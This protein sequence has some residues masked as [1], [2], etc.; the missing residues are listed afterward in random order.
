MYDSIRRVLS[1]PRAELWVL[2]VATLLVAP[3]ISAG[4]AADDFIHE[5]ALLG[6]GNPLAGFRRAPLDLFWFA[7]PEFNPRLLDEGVVPWWIDPSVRFAFFRPLA[8]ATHWLDHLLVPGNAVVMHLHTVL[9]HVAGLV[10]VRSLFR[11]ILGPGWVATLALCLYALDDARGAP[12]AWVANRNELIALALSVWAITWHHQGR[13]GDRLRARLAPAVLGVAML[14]SEGAIAVTAY[15]FAYTLFLDEGTRRERLW[16]LA[17]YALVVVA[18]AALYRGLGYGVSRSGLYFDPLR[19]PVAFA[20]VFPERFTMLWLAQLGGPW[21]EGWNAYPVMFPGLEYVVVVLAGVIIA[22]TFA[23]FLPLLRADKLARFWLTGAVVGTLPACGGFPGDRLLPW[24]GIGAMGLTAQFFA[25]VVES[26]P[27]PGFRGAAAR[28]GAFAIIVAH[29]GLGPLL[30]PLRAAG[31]AQVRGA[32]DRADRTIPSDR[33]VEQR[34]VIYVNPAADPFASYI[35]VTRAALGIPRPRSQRWLATGT[36]PVHVTR[37]DERTLRVRPE[38]GFL[39]MPSERMLR[40]TASHPF[41]VGE[42]IALDELQVTIS[43]VTSDGRPAEALERFARPLED[44]AY[45]WLSWQGDGYGPFT[46]PAIGQE[47]TAPAADLVTVA[48]GQD[49]WITRALGRTRR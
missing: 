5:L 34:L 20:R 1:R 17:P 24:V 23:L 10:A 26:R 36:T 19:D 6:S 37:V 9:W 45:L 47:V 2:V 40:N 3:S 38:G 18:W 30:L 46:P 48:Y 35:P 49:S 8:S 33:S 32:L 31:I 25:T 39:I 42:V 27:A 16:R 41:T 29:L 11:A 28:L 21:S 13:S 4:L 44:P 7:S 22:G 15:L 43:M 14:A 12:V